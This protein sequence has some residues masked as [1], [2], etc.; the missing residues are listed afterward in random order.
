RRTSL[1]QRIY[2]I[3]IDHVGS[4][5]LVYGATEGRIVQRLDYDEFGN[6]TR[7]ET[8][9]GFEGIPFGFAGG[10]SDPLTGLVRFGA[11]DY[12]PEVG[13]WTAKEPLRFAGGMNLY[14]YAS[15]D[16]EIKS[17]TVTG[18][19]LEV[20]TSCAGNAVQKSCL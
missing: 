20:K 14:V 5:R 4:P 18:D 3:I 1:G 2:R 15:N 16:P 9:L 12:D 7:I 6:V 8:F 19:T 11:R 17:I 13:R 10:L